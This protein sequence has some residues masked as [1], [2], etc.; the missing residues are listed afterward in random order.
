MVKVVE[1]PCVIVSGR[2]GL[3]DVRVNPSESAR[4]IE[5]RV[6]FVPV[7]SVSVNLV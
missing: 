7:S 5:S 6:W 1:E 2:F 4:V 3:Y